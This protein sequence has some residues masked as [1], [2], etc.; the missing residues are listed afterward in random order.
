TEKNQPA[1]WRV[2][3]TLKL[4][5]NDFAALAALISQLQ[6]DGGLVIDGTQFTV[7]DASRKKAEEALTQQAI[8]AWQARATEAASG[9]GVDRW[10]VVKLAIQR[11]DPGRPQPMMRAMAFEAKAA[12]VALEAGNTDVTVTV[13][14]YA[15]LEAPRPSR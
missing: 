11:G 14:G 10:L 6:G 7:S 9:F 3:Q 2:A 4:E 1:R 8:K 13:A 12:P 15:R 5:S